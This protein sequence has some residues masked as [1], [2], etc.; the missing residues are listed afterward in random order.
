MENTEIK[1]MYN[2]WLNIEF[3][4]PTTNDIDVRIFNAKKNLIKFLYSTWMCVG[5]LY[6]KETHQ[7]IKD[8]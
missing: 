3:M 7:Y 2:K 6:T 8:L 4:F 1:S 5:W